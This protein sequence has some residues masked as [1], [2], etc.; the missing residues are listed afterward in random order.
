MVYDI[1]IISKVSAPARGVGR[2][3]PSTE[4]T[5][6]ACFFFSLITSLRTVVKRGPLLLDS[7]CFLESADRFCAQNFDGKDAIITR[8]QLE[9]WRSW[10]LSG[11]LL[12]S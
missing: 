2:I 12:K 5:A 8:N 1:L 7:S 10:E 9:Q 3:C 6:A 4:K 11:L